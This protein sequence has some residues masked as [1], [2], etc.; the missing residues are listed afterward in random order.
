MSGFRKQVKV[1]AALIRATDRPHSYLIQQRLDGTDRGSLWEFPGGKIKP[2]ENTREALIRE[3]WEE[4][5]VRIESG[6]K[7]WETVHAYQDLDVHL[8]IIEATIVTGTPKPLAAQQLRYAHP[9]EMR[10]LPFCEADLPLIDLLS[11]RS[12]Q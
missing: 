11:V 1:V 4:L 10:R 7:I 5:E 12:L 6:L 9:D 2:G 8:E 3:C